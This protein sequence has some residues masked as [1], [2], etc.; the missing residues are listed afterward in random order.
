M[1]LS[2]A[3]RQRTVIPGSRFSADFCLRTKDLA[4]QTPPFWE[5]DRFLRRLAGRENGRNYWV[6][7]CVA[8][9]RLK[10][11]EYF[12]VFSGARAAPPGG[13]GTVPLLAGFETVGGAEGAEVPV[14]ALPGPR[15]PAAVN[16]TVRSTP[17]LPASLAGAGQTVENAPAALLGHPRG[18]LS[19]NKRRR[20]E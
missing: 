20:R 14:N 9:M 11:L 1:V 10:Y 5:P 17:A 6:F 4:A 2:G 8:N 7:S 12:R 18:R 16:V 3:A 19:T 13:L 15:A